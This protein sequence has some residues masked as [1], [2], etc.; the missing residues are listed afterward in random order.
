VGWHDRRQR[1]CLSVLRGLG[2]AASRDIEED[3]M[4]QGSVTPMTAAV[5]AGDPGRDG[6][7]A[8]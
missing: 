7:G 2:I 4:A 6:G 3:G 8:P 1:L 5:A